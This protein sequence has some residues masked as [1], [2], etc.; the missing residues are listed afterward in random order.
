MHTMKGVA[1][2]TEEQPWTLWDQKRAENVVFCLCPGPTEV[3]KRMSSARSVAVSGGFDAPWTS[4][5]RAEGQTRKEMCHSGKGRGKR[6]RDQT[7]D[8]SP[9]PPPLGPQV[10]IGSDKQEGTAPDS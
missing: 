6:T 7:V 9:P 1:A 5:E 8:G 3:R 4:P 2:A 10:T